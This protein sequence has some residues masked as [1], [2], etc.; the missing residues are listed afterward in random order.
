MWSVYVLMLVSLHE[1]G[2]ESHSKFGIISN[3]RRGGVPLLI[4]RGR[5]RRVI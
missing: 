3:W 5:I 4:S 1:R 2:F